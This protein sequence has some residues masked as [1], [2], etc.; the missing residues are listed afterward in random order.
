MSTHVLHLQPQTGAGAREPLAEAVRE[1]SGRMVT[2]NDERRRLHSRLDELR[3]A[4]P[5][6]R[7]SRPRPLPLDPQRPLTIFSIEEAAAPAPLRE[8]VGG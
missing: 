2:L 4:D 1:V 5:T 6:V 8:A 3:S 7:R